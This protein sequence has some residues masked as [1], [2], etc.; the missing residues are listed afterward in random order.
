[1]RGAHRTAGSGR[2]WSATAS[3]SRGRVL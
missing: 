2:G 1:M 3:S